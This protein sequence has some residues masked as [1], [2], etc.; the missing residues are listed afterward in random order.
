MNVGEA[1]SDAIQI[2]TG[3][4]TIVSDLTY[5]LRGGEADFLDRLI[6]STWANMAMDCLLEKQSGLMMALVDGRHERMP[7]PDAHAGP[8]HVEV[9]TMY[10]TKRFRPRFAGKTGLPIFLDRLDRIVPAATPAV[11]A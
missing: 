8:K 2:R 10:D 11:V 5:D 4:E 9:S 7:I 1:F 3:E 6:G